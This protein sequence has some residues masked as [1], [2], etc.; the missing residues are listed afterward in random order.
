[1]IWSTL[2]LLSILS[3]IPYEHFN[4]N[5]KEA[6]RSTSTRRLT[7]TC[8]TIRNLDTNIA[9][10]HLTSRNGA[11]SNFSSIT[12]L[13]PLF[14]LF[15]RTVSLY[16]F[17]LWT[18]CLHVSNCQSLRTRTSLSVYETVSIKT[19]FRNSWTGQG[20]IGPVWFFHVPRPRIHLLRA[21]RLCIGSVFPN[22]WRLFKRRRPRRTIRASFIWKT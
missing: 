9:V 10:R 15:F 22:S 11:S 20:R 6:Y 21:V 18:A 1:M 7:R 16:H 12:S 4:L 8:D 5:I 14:G 17:N 3:E 19:Q 13:T 2:G